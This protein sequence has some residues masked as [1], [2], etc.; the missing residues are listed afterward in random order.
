M[1]LFRSYT[2]PGKGLS[3]EDVE[4][5]G[6]ALYFDIFARRFGKLIS[7]NLMYLLFSIPA[8]I[9]SFFIANYLMDVVI[10]YRYETT[11][12]P[13][14]IYATMLALVVPFTATILQATGSGPATIAINSI[15][16]KYVKDTHC[17]VWSDF[18]DSFK[19]NFLQGMAIYII[20]TLVF[21]ACAFSF[22]FYNYMGGAMSGVLRTLIM[23]VSIVFFIMQFYTYRIAAEFELKT[24]HIYKNAFLLT[25]VGLKWNLFSAIVII[26]L[27]CLFYTLMVEISAVGIGFLLLIYFVLLTFTQN[28]ITNNVVKKYLLEPSLKMQEEAENKSNDEEDED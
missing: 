11:E 7:V 4:K 19:R 5:T 1:A 18:I 8:I 21:F 12:V 24:K 22:L 17:W 15:T 23:I 16:G 27:M 6:I 26:A 25:I 2:K 20:N 10:A 3:K 13:K 28:F 14:D 9:I